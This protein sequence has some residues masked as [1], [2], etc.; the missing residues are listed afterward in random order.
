M[1]TSHT[2]QKTGQI[3]IEDIEPKPCLAE[4]N[5]EKVN[6]IAAIFAFV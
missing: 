1:N 2:K 5:S 6:P 4:S 3:I